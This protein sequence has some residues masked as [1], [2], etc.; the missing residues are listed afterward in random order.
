MPGYIKHNTKP[1]DLCSNMP[2][3]F[4]TFLNHTKELKFEQRPRYRQM[5]ALFRNVLTRL[6]VCMGD[7]KYDWDINH[8]PINGPSAVATQ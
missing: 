5:S 1:E 3:E 6:G 4:K 2:S 7:L 8:Q